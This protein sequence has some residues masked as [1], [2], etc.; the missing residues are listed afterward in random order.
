MTTLPHHS[1]GIESAHR[2]VVIDFSNFSLLDAKSGV[3]SITSLIEWVKSYPQRGDV[4][5]YLPSRSR[6][7]EARK[8]QSV[9]L[10]LG[11]TVTRRMDVCHD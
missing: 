8:L 1:P 4:H 3:F 9:L 11:C 10:S 5:V 6:F 2:N 7:S